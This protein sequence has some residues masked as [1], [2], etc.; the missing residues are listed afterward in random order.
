MYPCEQ[1]MCENTSRDIFPSNK[2]SSPLL[3]GSNLDWV[4]SLFTVVFRLRVRYR[5][6]IK[7]ATFSHLQVN[8]L[9]GKQEWIGMNGTP[10]FARG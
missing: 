2:I 4:L 5:K 10:V 3:T 6:T 7:G 9:G 1:K 8:E